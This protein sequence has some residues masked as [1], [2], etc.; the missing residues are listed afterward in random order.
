MISGL[1]VARVGEV[2][3]NGAAKPMR[4][5]RMRA[6]DPRTYAG[7]P[8][9]L[10]MARRP[11]PEALRPVFPVNGQKQRDFSPF[12]PKIGKRS[13][14][15]NDSRGLRLLSLFSVTPKPSVR[16]R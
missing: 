3:V 12:G 5:A 16:R 4:A 1:S 9:L 10:R 2:V 15:I 7:K 8:L 13:K 6:A 14:K 11:H